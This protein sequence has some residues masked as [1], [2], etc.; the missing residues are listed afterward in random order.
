MVIIQ[1]H[2]CPTIYLVKEQSEVEVALYFTVI[3]DVFVIA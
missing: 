3:L 1:N 2:N